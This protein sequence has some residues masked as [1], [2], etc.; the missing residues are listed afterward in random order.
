MTQDSDRPVGA[1]AIACNLG[2]FS[3]D[4][5]QR[6][7]ALRARVMDAVQHATETPRG[8]RA[9][10]SGIV[11]AGDIAEWISLEQRC[12]P[13]L[14]LRLHPAAGDRTHWLD[15]EGGAGVKELLREEF[16]AL[17]A[18]NDPA[19]AERSRAGLCADC[20]FAR[21]IESARGSVFYLCERSASDPAFAKYPR[22]PVRRCSGHEPRTSTP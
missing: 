16:D 20:R 2:A 22:L 19:H 13:F 21:R 4:E 10:V 5:R 7:H 11:S 8:F 1:M 18:V 15:L 14:E 12:C 9:S 3:P 17:R 6:Y